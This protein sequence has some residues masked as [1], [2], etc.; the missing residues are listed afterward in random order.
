MLARPDP[1]RARY[2]SWLRLGGLVLVTLQLLSVLPAC[3]DS[4]PTVPATTVTP[5]PPVPDATAAITPTSD[6]SPT[7]TYSAALEAI[8]APGN[9]APLPDRFYFR[10]GADI[11]RGR[12]DGSERPRRVA[13][14]LRIGPWSRTPNGEQAAIVSYLD[15]DG[16]G[17]EEIR[18]VRGDEMVEQPLYGPA[19]ISGGRARPS[20]TSIDWSWDGT[21]LAVS[22]A[23]GTLGILSV[24]ADPA[25]FPIEPGEIAR[26]VDTSG[27]SELAW[28]PNGAGVAYASEAPDGRNLLFITPAGDAARP[29]IDTRP[30]RTFEWMPGRGRLAFVEDS[31]GP[32]NRLPGSIFTVAPDGGSLELLLS[33]GRF[34]PAATI[35]SIDASP[36]GRE[37]AVTVAVPD[38]DGRPRFHSL[39]MLSI[40][41]GELREA[42]IAAGFKVVETWWTSAGLVWRGIDEAAGASDGG[43]TGVEPFVLGRFDAESGASTIIFQQ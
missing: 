35:T 17:A 11:W 20:I 41:S 38:T 33:A 4:E 36:D 30:V 28:S 8:L 26:P 31:G 27:I 18:I 40:D 10:V 32:S 34:A 37:M 29:V 25:G 16:Q 24:P 3:I 42:P 14:D 5:T 19:T 15:I 39:W 23:D 7:P 6:V 21:K 2:P 9:T 13:T 1:T 12:A 22:F 43:Y